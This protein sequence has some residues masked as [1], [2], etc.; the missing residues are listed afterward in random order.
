MGEAVRQARRRRAHRRI[1]ASP[2]RAAATDSSSLR[3][4]HHLWRSAM[5]AMTSRT[6]RSRSR[7]GSG[8]ARQAR[9]NNLA[10][11]SQI[12]LALVA[13]SSWY[14]GRVKRTGIR[15]WPIHC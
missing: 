5:F 9:M 14:V 10:S 12:G 3:R 2:G 6:K 4:C 7:A 1:T 13:L 8:R 11:L 15:G